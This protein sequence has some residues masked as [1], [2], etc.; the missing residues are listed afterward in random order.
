MVLSLTKT[1]VKTLAKN[2]VISLAKHLV[3]QW[4]EGLRPLAAPGGPGRWYNYGGGRPLKTQG[5]L[6]VYMYIIQRMYI[7]RE[8][9]VCF[10]AFCLLLS[11]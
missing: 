7:G 10:A 11:S 2:L 4:F 1:L 9:C 8:I 5:P 3:K 6:P